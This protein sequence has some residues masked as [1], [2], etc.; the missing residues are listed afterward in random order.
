MRSNMKKNKGLMSINTLF[1]GGLALSGIIAFLSLGTFAINQMKAKDT[2]NEI[3]LLKQFLNNNEDVT[4][5]KP[6]LNLSM[7]HYNS[8]A[9]KFF[10]KSDRLPIYAK[11]YFDT[12]LKVNVSLISLDAPDYLCNSIAPIVNDFYEVFIVPRGTTPVNYDNASK[13]IKIKNG[14]VS[15]VSIAKLCGKD[16]QL[17][18]KSIKFV[19][20]EKYQ[21][22]GD[23]KDMT[24]EQKNVIDTLQSEEM[25]LTERRNKRM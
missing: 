11:N 19:S 15:G 3:L 21:Q 7:L 6:E 14:E 24:D 5:L 8:S 9:R 22:W 18:F 12:D 10:T 25:R 23:Y 20:R 13:L 17:I 1:A 16:S 2:R 4:E